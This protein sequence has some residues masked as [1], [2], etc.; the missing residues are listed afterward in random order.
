[1]DHSLGLHSHHVI[2][3]VEG[4]VPGTRRQRIR[5]VQPCVPIRWTSRAV[6]AAIDDGRW[7][8]RQIARLFRVSSRSSPGSEARWKSA[9]WTRAAPRQAR[10]GC[11][12]SPR[13]ACS[14]TWSRARDYTLDEPGRRRLHLLPDDDLRPAAARPDPQKK[15]MYADER[16]RPTSSGSGG[17]SGIG[18]GGSSP[19]GCISS[20]SRGRTQRDG[21][22]PGP[23]AAGR[24]RPRAVKSFTMIAALG[25]DGACPAGHPGAARRGGVQ[26]ACLPQLR[27]GD[28]VIWDRIPTHPA[29]AAAAVHRAGRG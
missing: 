21:P 7:S 14:G 1:V 27:P 16:D 8:Q 13:G 4:L 24:R 3:N 5:R 26:P 18:C 6:A 28:V 12:A 2:M 22:T 23:P 20:T 9:P 29:R 10:P 15:S 17:R 19:G 11:S 25:L